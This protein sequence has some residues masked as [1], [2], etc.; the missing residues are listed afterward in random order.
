[1]SC[2]ATLR[3]GSGCKFSAQGVCSAPDIDL[4]MLVH[5]CAFSMGNHS[6]GLQNPRRRCQD[7]SLCRRNAGFRASRK[8][9]GR[10]GCCGLFS[11]RGKPAPSGATAT[12]P[13]ACDTRRGTGGGRCAASGALLRRNPP[14]YMAGSDSS[15][16]ALA[17]CTTG[18]RGRDGRLPA[19]T[20]SGCCAATD[21][22][23]CRSGLWTCAAMSS[24]TTACCCRRRSRCSVRTAESA[25][26]GP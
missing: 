16:Y 13:S 25:V 2:P 5:N 17:A 21:R 8:I 1:M 6:R 10:S 14:G 20:A 4:T 3:D 24:M 18:G 9:F 19:S 23:W 26:Y 11:A 22:L 12:T 15:E 7:E